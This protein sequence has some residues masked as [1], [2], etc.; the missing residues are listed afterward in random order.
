MLI[1]YIDEHEVC[2]LKPCWN[3]VTVY[4]KILKRFFI[5]L[6]KFLETSQT[7][8]VFDLHV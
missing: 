3:I 5:P 7:A 1:K 4:I 8:M 2:I 6:V